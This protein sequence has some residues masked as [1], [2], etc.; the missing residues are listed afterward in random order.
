[1]ACPYG[2]TEDGFETQFGSN[3]LAHFLFTALI[4]PSLVAAGSA[5]SPSRVV[6]V[7]SGG[8]V[9]SDIRLDDYNFSDGAKYTEM[10]GYGQSKTAN[11]LFANE[12]ARRSKEKGVP[13]LGFSLHPGY[14]MIHAV[15]GITCCWK[16]TKHLTESSS[17]T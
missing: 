6:N 13:V 10:E 11:I 9:C 1:M 17:Q 4:F 8:H 5:A 2:K 12:I 15:H 7:S 16:L 14:G 3:H